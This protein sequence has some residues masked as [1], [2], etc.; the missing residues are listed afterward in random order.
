MFRGRVRRIHL[1]GVGGTGMNGIAEVLL[2]LGFAVSGSDL[3]AGE[4]CARLG[5][6]GVEVHHGHAAEHV[7]GADVVVRSTAVRA[8]NVEIEAAVA[9]G[10][11]VIRRAE[12]LAELMRMKHGLAVAGT[13]GK[14][15]VTSML[16]TCL[17]GADLDPTVIIGGRLDRLGAS[18][19]V[20]AGPHLVAEA[21]ESDGSFMLLAPTLA[22]VTNIEPEHLDHYGSFEALVETFVE[23]ANKVPFY[24]CTVICLDDPVAR[25]LLPRIRRRVVTYGLSGQADLRAEELGYS[26]FESRFAVWRGA[27]RLGEVCLGMPGVHNVRNA[28]AAIA[29]AMEL[30]IPFGVAAGALEGFTG[31]QR[32]FTLR[33]EA[34][35]RMVVDDYGHHPSEIAATLAAARRGF[36]ERRLVAVFQPHRF[37]RVAQLQAEFARCFDP[38]DEVLV[39]PIY[40]AGEEPIPGVDHFALAAA[41]RA[42]GHRA[43]LPMADLD[44]AV[45]H[46]LQRG[47]PGDLVVT[48][49]AGDV[50]RVCAVLLERLGGQQG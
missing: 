24:G 28:V 13:H 6:L 16:A 40:R 2:S 3:R 37:S 41:M 39:C 46:L 5:S 36:P 45:E 11:P 8:D 4:V 27:E 14:T 25:E 17:H 12:M 20:G 9:R 35:G 34:A 33:G 18:A 10:I 31:V 30:D 29:A 43:A 26:A 1:V 22:V 47:G 21:D 32:R 7:V 44:A 38:A 50:N 48:L 19:R 15:T 49:G 42:R 23:F